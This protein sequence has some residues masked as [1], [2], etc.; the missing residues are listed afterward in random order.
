MKKQH[1]VMIAF[2]LAFVSGIASA[3][4]PLVLDL[5]AETPD[6][7]QTDPSGKF[8]GKG[9]DFCGPV[10]V[11]NS[12]VYLSKRGF[13]KLQPDA[14]NGHAAQIA[15]IQRLA[16]PDFMDTFDRKG[17]SPPRLM[18]GVQKLVEEAGYQVVR[19][20][21]Q[22]WKEATKQYP[23]QAEVPSLT[24]MKAALATP[25]GAVWLNVGWYKADAATNDYVRFGGHW[26]TLVGYGK[27]AAGNDDPRTVLIHDPAPRTGK[28]PVTQRVCL[29]ELTTG[30]L[31]RPTSPTEVRRRP[32]KGFWEL[33][34][35]MKLKVGADAAV[36][37]AVV[38]LELK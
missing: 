7:C 24:W 8:A 28:A 34:D 31:Q 22:G 1:A 3:E 26:V 36:L 38:V 15:L 4:M 30:T 14:A 12:L 6:F 16:S 19:L 9:A 23:R 29:H 20:E 35:E 2:V 5:S 11:S 10:S 25:G 13:P 17:T 32:A 33:K 21:Q 18:A 27:D 37:D